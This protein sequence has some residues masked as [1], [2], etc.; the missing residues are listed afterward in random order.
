LSRADGETP[1]VPPRTPPYGRRST[2]HGHL[3]FAILAAVAIPAIVA[4]CWHSV[5]A[6]IGDDSVSYITL[7]RY[8][9]PWRPDPLSAPWAAY[10]SNFPPLFPALLALTGGAYDL[11]IGHMVVAAGA[12]VSLA[13]VHYYARERLSSDAGALAVT[14]LFLLL[15]GM[16]LGLVGILSESTYLALSVAALLYEARRVRPD[17]SAWAY[18]ALGGWIAAALLSRTAGLALLAA[19]AA[20]VVVGA[21]RSRHLPAPRL[22]LPIAIAL[23]A[24]LAWLWLRPKLAVTAYEWTIGNLVHRWVEQPVSTFAESWQYLSRAWIGNFAADAAGGSSAALAYG[25]VALLALGGAVRAALHNRLDGWYMLAS[26]GMLFLW[27]FNEDNS[28]RLLYP[29]LPLVLLHAAEAVRA[30]AARLRSPLGR[31]IPTLAFAFLAVMVLPASALI[32]RKALDRDPYF[33]GLEYSPASMKDYYGIVSAGPAGVEAF[34]GASV[35]GGMSYLDQWT[36]PGSRVMW[37]RPEYI[38]VLGRREGVPL[39]LRWDRPTFAREI[40][41][42]RTDF[43][44]ASRHFK[45]DMATDVADA[46]LWLALDLPDY[47]LPVAALPDMKTGDFTLLRV[48]AA[49]LQSYI[50]ATEGAPPGPPGPSRR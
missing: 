8:L 32:L 3:A 5:V 4:F 10:F 14:A 42:T 49:R 28:R 31:W 34:R 46:F 45:N 22:W 47:L 16:W 27:V 37:V 26:V 36:P 29:L 21:V 9:A 33:S 18:A 30:L 1:E 12:A 11:F 40:L 43:V 2:F 19:Y 17:S 23:A 35:L 20:K 24:Q 6:T 50:R 15:P 39:Y 48:D 25:I 41:R 7:A 38:A 44:I 13:L